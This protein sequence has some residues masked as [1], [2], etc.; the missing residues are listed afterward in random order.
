MKQI[1]DILKEV[2]ITKPL[3]YKIPFINPNELE[4][5]DFDFQVINRLFERLSL[6]CP[7]F[8]Q[9]W[10]SQVDYDNAKKEWVRAFKLAKMFDVEK[11][12]FGIETYSLLDKAFVPSVGQFIEICKKPNIP[13]YHKDYLKITDSS[14]TKEEIAKHKELINPKYKDLKSFKSAFSVMKELLK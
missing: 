8:K 9:A 4:F 12:K 13:E 14:Y 5:T 7:A 2:S 6:L 3:D 11:I 1:D 10:P